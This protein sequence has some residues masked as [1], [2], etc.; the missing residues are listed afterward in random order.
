M[1]NKDYYQVLGIS[2]EAS[3][4]DVKKAYRKLAHQYHPDKN[5]GN[6]KK[7]KEI[8]EA[9][10]VLSNKEKRAQYDRFG[11]VF[12]G[13]FSNGGGN[14]FGEGFDFR[15][16]SDGF[17]AQGG[18]AS[19][20]EDF[21]NISDIFDAFFEGIGV[22]KR[23]TYQRGS[24]VELHQQITLEEAFTGTAKAIK[25]KTFIGCSKCGGTGYFPE[26]GLKDCSA[27][28]GRG[29]I[30]E[31]RS[32]IFGSFQQIRP[33]GKCNSVG[34]IPNKICGVCSHSGRV[35]A[36]KEVT[37]DIVPGVQEGQLI[38]LPGAGEKGERG[39]ESGDLYVRISIK[40]NQIFKR[41]GDD[42]VIK[43]EVDIVDVLLDKKIELMTIGGGN[44]EVEIPKGFNLKERLVIKGEGMSRLGGYGKGNLLVEL[45]IKTP[46]KLSA[47]A[48][49][50][51]EELEK[52]L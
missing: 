31:S 34:Q 3:D 24:D 32:T 48:K 6:D 42:L 35:S 26:E 40:P 12:D 5:G 10:Q 27:C 23:R 36:E 52:E 44:L 21:G 4:E 25:F 50:L 47:K 51:L 2:K 49:K 20:W 39:A 14:P 18:P 8:N 46:K 43:K 37:I 13:N 17:S 41:H 28:N 22:K 7:F 16:F 15:N 19:G 9:Y 29:E 45:E 1:N 33:C 11:R 38:K 30:K